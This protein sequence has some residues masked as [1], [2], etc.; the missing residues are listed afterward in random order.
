MEPEMDP[1][2]AG[3]LDA[4][5]T[6]KVANDYGLVGKFLGHV[7]DLGRAGIVGGYAGGVK[8]MARA[9]ALQ[10]AGAS[11]A[12]SHLSAAPEALLEAAKTFHRHGGTGSA[13]VVG[14]VGL[15]AYGAHQLYQNHVAPHLPQGGEQQD[16]YPQPYAGMF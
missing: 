4:C 3:A 12:A 2:L 13:G 14:G 16:A 11:A 9:R 8:H 6:F 10:E 15:G 7:H 5:A 1:K